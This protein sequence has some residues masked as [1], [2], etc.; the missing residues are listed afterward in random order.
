MSS[1][2]KIAIAALFF[3]IF[4]IIAWIIFY[5]FIFYN[6][7]KNANRTMVE[8]YYSITK[9]NDLN[10]FVFGG[11]IVFFNIIVSILNIIASAKTNYKTAKILTIL[12]TTLIF[13]FPIIAILAMVGLIMIIVHNKDVVKNVANDPFAK[14]ANQY[15]N[16][17]KIEQQNL[18]LNNEN[19]NQEN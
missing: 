10:I 6:T 19:N 16:Q 5:A 17:P 18:F 4:I 15:D 3:L 2:K 13:V 8:N 11:V 9:F 14:Q 12:G 7:F 1:S